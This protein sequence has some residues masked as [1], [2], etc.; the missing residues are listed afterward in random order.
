[1]VATGPRWWDWFRMRRAERAIAE[2]DGLRAVAILLVVARHGVNP[3]WSTGDGLVPV[4]GWDLGIPLSNGWMGVDLF[5]VLSG[6][7]ITHQVLTRYGDG[8]AGS[9]IGDYVR[10][11]LLRIVPAY[12][13]TIAI[14]VSGI[15][16]FAEIEPDHLPIR[17]GYHLL[18]LQDYLRSDI[19]VALWSLGVEEKF[20]LLAPLVLL[21]VLSLPSGPRRYG[22]LVALA[23]APILFRVLTARANP[24]IIDY[25]TY[26]RVYRSPF[27][28]TYDG[29]AVG[30]L[31][32]FLHRDRD[33]LAK[34]GRA[35]A[36][37]LLLLGC[38][39]FGLLLL[40]RPHLDAIGWFD[41]IGLQAALAW[42]AGAMV[43]G[44]VLGGGS[45]RLLTSRPMFVISRL[46]YAWYLLHLLFV[47]LAL[48]VTDAVV[49]TGPAGVGAPLP[50]RLS[51]FVP[52]YV[53][54]SL[55]AAVVLHYVIER[56]FVELR[57]RRPAA[58]DRATTDCPVDEAPAT[59]AAPPRR[60]T[61]RP[62]PSLPSAR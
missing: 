37:P 61:V 17:I 62:S 23:L 11:R 29:L 38:A 16:P 36:R 1:M 51:V 55:L 30:V 20:Y 3:F 10:R 50:A 33:L 57:D 41:R 28:V 4:L 18:F 60:P 45:S 8:F 6:F 21:G 14:A 39:T 19:V 27:H 24:D 49:G 58:P 32:A 13:A 48:R 12:L 7:L 26:F 47:P 59:R 2:L 43:G 25:P 56:P 53:L 52:V 22:S 15:I 9:D 46:S 34:R 35:V 31:V 42:S 5:F 40:G 54:T 44:L